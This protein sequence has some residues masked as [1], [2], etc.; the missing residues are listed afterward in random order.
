MS[1]I[2][3]FRIRSAAFELGRI[4]SVED[5]TFMELETLVPLGETN[6]PLIWVFDATDDS[7]VE[8]VQPHPNVDRAREMDVFDDRTLF[9]LDWDANGDQ[10]FRGL[11]ANGGQLLSAIGTPR[12]WKFE[13]RFPDY[14]DL[15]EFRSH[16]EDANVSL[17]IDRVYDP[18]ETDAGPWYGLT[19]PQRTAIVLAV[20]KGYY[21][22]PRRCSTKALAEQL[23]ISDQAVTE[24]LRRAID[25]LVRNTLVVSEET[26]DE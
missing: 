19:E 26:F 2:T 5:P 9:S 20:K 8:A 16:C 15:G 1:V 25:V 17:E 12:T 7:F 3:E 13:V 11:R 10:F 22:L 18:T 23:G 14:D 24:R 4:L 6:A 21:S